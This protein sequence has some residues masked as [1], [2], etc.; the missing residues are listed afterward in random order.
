MERILPEK[1]SS[2]LPVGGSSKILILFPLYARDTVP[3]IV[4]I[5]WIACRS[6]AATV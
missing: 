1:I 2:L 3:S 4:I 5:D 6:V